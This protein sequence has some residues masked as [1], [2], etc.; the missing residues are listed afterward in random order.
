MQQFQL[1]P[2]FHRQPARLSVAPQVTITGT[3][4]TGATAVSFGGA[5]AT[6]VTVVN[7]TAVTATT[8]AHA[9]GTVDITVTTPGGT[10]AKSSADQYTYAAAPTVTSLS[11]AAGPIA[12]GTNITITGTALTGATA[13]S[14]GVT[15]ATSF[16]VVNATTITAIAPAVIAGIVDVTVTTPGGISTAVLHDKYMYQA[17][18][19]VT[20]ISPVAGP[21]TGGTIVT[22]TGTAFTGAS[23]VTFGSTAA[24]HVTVVNATAVTATVPANTTA[25][26]V[27][28]TI[29][30]P[31]GTSAVVPADQFT[32]QAPPTVTGISPAAGPTAG[33]T[34]ITIT[35][36]NLTNATAVTFGSTAA[37]HVT[38][39]NATA[40]TATAPA[41]AAGTVDVTI[42]TPG[43]T[44]AKSSAD[45]YA[46]VAPPA[47]TAVAPAATPWYRNATVLFLITGANFVPGQ[48]TVTFS[49]PSNG[50]ALNPAGFT[51]NTVTATTI[52]GS[53]VVP[54]NAPTG[55][56]NVSVT[57][58]YGGQVWKAAAF[59]VSNFPAPTIT[60]ITYPPGNIGTTVLFTITG[61]NFQTDST[62][63]SVTIYNDVTNTVLPT[64][65]LSIMPTTII[66]S[67][68]ISSST[69]AGAYNVNVTT[70]DGG[71][72]SRPGSFT[73]GFVGI[74]T[75]T[76][77]TPVSGFLNT[78]VNFTVTGTSFEPG[79]T[80]VAFTNQT[81]SQTLTPIFYNVTSSTQISG[82]VSIPFNALSGPYRL[83][84]TTTDGGVVNKPNAFTVNAFPA[85]TITSITPTTPWYRNATVPF[86]ITGT[87]FKSGQT[88]VAFNYPSNG[89]ALNST[90]AVNAVS[91]TT[92]SGTVVVPYSAPTGT[93]NVSVATIDGGTVWKP[94]AITVNQFPAPSITSITPAAGT[95]N[96]PVLFT[97]AGTNFEP[98]GTSVTIVEDT[99]GTVM[100]ATLI[101]VTPGSIVGN[102]TI[103]G[104][105]PAGL[106]RLQVTTVDG[107]TVSKPQA[108]TVNYLP[109][110][111]ITTLAPATGYRNTTVSFTL[112][113]NYFL[114][115]GTTVMLRTVGTTLPASTTFV[116]TTTIQGS[117]IIPSDAPTG[118]YTM[119]VITTGGGFNSKP[120]AFKVI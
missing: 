77:L 87:N 31:G 107:G 18:S 13:V 16:V 34:V 43:G 8:P 115:G 37:T 7:A 74:P 72:A 49:Y 41:H 81:T 90:V 118:S 83:D 61:T 64:T 30:T 119:Y 105:V 102:V 66:G 57:T 38:V 120:N 82:N 6:Q 46:Y 59:T 62:K 108:F 45:Q 28:V 94:A 21:L 3:S 88:T 19:T 26:T 14:F 99:S 22:I 79:S 113:G 48:T 24:T 36:T 73:V 110:P 89:T 39:V 10:S 85:P 47:V 55:T 54:L 100:N 32:Y 65:V 12:G 51:V 42:T 96:G 95:K 2:A 60:S 114:N 1:S 109:L 15:A 116:N 33:G 117:F 53:V 11:P 50:T 103:P 92:I 80:V 56:W 27:D 97:L 68:T 71:T 20:G 35:G 112:T 75:I 23:G 25:G 86:L 106:Y 17:V 52:N 44:S 98:V 63:T 91:A 9:A 78:T 69:P 5:A 70:V 84:I 67:A 76:S 111:V 4:L 104:S 58:L 101:S 40:V 93:W 29:T